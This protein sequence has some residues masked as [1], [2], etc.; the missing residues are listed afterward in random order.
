MKQNYTMPDD[1]SGLSALLCVAEKLSFTAAAS[2]LHVTPSAVSQTV[3]ALED[4]VGVRLLQRT[5]RSVSLTEAGARFVAELKPA[6]AGV[7]EAFDSLSALRD[8][9]AG[10]LRLILSRSG[11]AYALEPLMA[12]FLAEYPDIKVE[13]CADERLVDIVAEGFDA[14]LRLGETLEREMIAVR[15]SEDQR[16]AV[17]A[18]PK[19]FALHGKPKHPRDLLAHDCINMRRTTS[20]DAYRWEFT[21]DGKDFEMAVDGRIVAN[22]AAIIIR[23]AVNGLGVAYLMENTIPSL[24]ADKQL[25]RVLD[26]YCPPFPGYFLYYPSRS[27]VAPKLRALVD[28]LTKRKAGRSRRPNAAATP[29]RGARDGRTPG[30]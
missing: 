22:D 23:M 1:L 28:F 6:L 17:V 19:Y 27:N 13:I 12:A 29:R 24:L 11:Y 8:R 7:H 16:V 18:S 20:G 30:T 26:A 14:G 5:T 3:R 15:V 21:E 9:P 25:V 10:L 2:D 4:R